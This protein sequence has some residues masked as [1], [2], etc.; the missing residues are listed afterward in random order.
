[1]WTNL[2][3]ILLGA[4]LAVTDYT[5]QKSGGVQLDLE[6]DPP[7]RVE[8]IYF[9]EV[10][11]GMDGLHTITRDSVVNYYKGKKE[12]YYEEEVQRHHDRRC[13]VRLD[14]F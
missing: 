2:T 13:R 12:G 6:Y 1:M 4:F 5:V 3:L 7:T 14:G 10:K 8:V 9:D 11:C